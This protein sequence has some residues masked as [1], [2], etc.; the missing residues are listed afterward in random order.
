MGFLIYAYGPEIPAVIRT[1][2][3]LKT[4]ES[5]KI[6]SNAQKFQSVSNV[7]NFQSVSMPKSFKCLEFSNCFKCLKGVKVS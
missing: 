1:H 5:N 4:F 7:L 3:N 2:H 6:V